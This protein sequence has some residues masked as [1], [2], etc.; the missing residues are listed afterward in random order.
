MPLFLRRSDSDMPDY[1]V[2]YR[3]DDGRELHVGRIF[4]PDAIKGLPW[5]WTVEFHQRKGRAEPHQ[6]HVARGKRCWESADVPI[7]W[8]PSLAKPSDQSSTIVYHRAVV[9]R[10][11][12]GG[13]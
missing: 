2:M 1:S 10:V 8:P 7:R 5:M 13:W 3:A 4:K 11:Q 12:E 9:L 6:E